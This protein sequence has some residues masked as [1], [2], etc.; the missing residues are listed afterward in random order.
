MENV[1]GFIEV[2]SGKISKM[3]LVSIENIWKSR[4]KTQKENIQIFHKKMMKYNFYEF[5][6]NKL[7][8][9]EK[10]EPIN[11]GEVLDYMIKDLKERDF[12]SDAFDYIYKY[13]ETE[14]IFRELIT[15]AKNS[16][17]ILINT[18][19]YQRLHYWYKYE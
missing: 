8:L 13:A 1:N 18:N 7:G 14:I 9:Y 2:D 6:L 5:I 15:S 11:D 17:K 19:I 12:F 3:C 16:E 10:K 4:E